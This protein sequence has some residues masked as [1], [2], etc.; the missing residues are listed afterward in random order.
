MSE[1]DQIPEDETV[2]QNAKLVLLD[3][4]LAEIFP[5][6]ESVNAALRKILELDADRWDRRFEED[7]AAGRLDT[8]AD[9]A[10]S[11]LRAGHTRPL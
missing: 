10:L 7:V 4:D 1:P 6:S 2:N 9:A 11:E 8:L 5:D 3:P